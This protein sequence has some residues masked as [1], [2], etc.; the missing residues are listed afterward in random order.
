MDEVW[1]D[2]IYGDIKINMYEVSNM[3]HIRNKLNGHMM[4][5]YPSEKGYMMA[6]LMINTNKSRSIKIH[7]IVAKTFIPNDDIDCTE[8]NHKN[9][10]KTDNSVSNLE[11][12]THIQ[13]IHHAYT[14][15][16]VPI[17]RGTDNGNSKL[18]EDDVRLICILL[19]RFCGKLSMVFHKVNSIKTDKRINIYNIIDIKTKRTWKHISDEYFDIDSINKIHSLTKDNIIAIC[20]EINNY[21]DN[22]ESVLL[23]LIDNIPFLTINMIKCIRD[24]IFYRKIS[25]KILNKI[26]K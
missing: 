19:V 13:N 5:L 10:N 4:S 8:V 16:M 1:K 12:V 21:S 7:R 24:G 26:D 20:H 22:V 9:G 11:W 15:N 25:S 6:T 18:S 14:N 2:I 23:L 17:L 3:G